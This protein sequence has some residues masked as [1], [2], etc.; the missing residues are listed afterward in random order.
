[1]D[2]GAAAA[3][4]PRSGVVGGSQIWRR[5]GGDSPIRRAGGVGASGQASGG[6]PGAL[7]HARG[8]GTSETGGQAA[9]ALPRQ[10]SDDVAPPGSSDGAM[11]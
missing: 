10:A 2:P 5:D 3:V 8:G 7:R 4:V 9:I 11:P 1:V 6:D